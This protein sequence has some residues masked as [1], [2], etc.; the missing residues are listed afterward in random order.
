MRT[1][2]KAVIPHV[3]DHVSKLQS[4]GVMTQNKLADIGAAAAAAGIT[5]ELNVPKNCV[6][7]GM[8][9]PSFVITW[10]FFPYRHRSRSKHARRGHAIAHMS[11]SWLQEH[12]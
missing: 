5:Y 11:L 8:P 7:T 9:A 2:V 1:A 4:L 10:Y 3:D 6:G 12:K